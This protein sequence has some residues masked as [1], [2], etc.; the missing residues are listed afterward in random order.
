M[1]PLK[2]FA[3][4]ISLLVLLITCCGISSA[5]EKQD[6]KTATAPTGLSLEVN[7]KGGPPSYH[8]VPGMFF[9]GRFRRL[10]SWQPLT[11]ATQPGTTFVLRHEM[12][13]D[14][15]RVKVFAWTDKFREHE[16]LI[17]DFLLREGERAAVAE[18]TKFG[19][20]PME[21]T[22]VKVKPATVLL[23]L[24]ESRL[25][26]VEVVNVEAVRANFPSFKVTLRN[27]SYK[28]IIFLEV[29]TFKAGVLVTSHWPRGEQDRPLVK[30][31]ETFE[32]SVMAGS[33][34][35][36]ET[37]G[38]TPSSP[39]RVEVVTAVFNDKSYEGRKESAAKFVAGQRARKIQI[40]RALVLLQEAAEAQGTGERAALGN[41][42]KQVYALDRNT[43]QST[44][45]E[46]LA[47][48]PGLPAPQV[49]KALKAFI[50]IGLDQV[51]KELL[52]D[53][54]E[55]AQ[56]LERDSASKPFSDW[57]GDLRQKYEAWSSRL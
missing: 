38:Y 24:A 25:P 17:G 19:Y 46:I 42:K 36:K 33:I 30:A 10:P 55:Y 32:E 6:N 21:L 41:L 23:P 34:G 14:A 50:E 3:H 57:L 22:I 2:G 44:I 35:L 4:A 52:K 47:E 18:M 9:G 16:V 27:L 7:P 43:P 28:D 54:G 13:G 49:N 40:T 12:E 11:D 8:S 26:S 29:E 15:V 1:R 53:I 56:T 5:Q 31:G 39:Q 45:D 51:R 37:D 48:F 20:E